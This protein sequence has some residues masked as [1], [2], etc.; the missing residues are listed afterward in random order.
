[1]SKRV[2]IE[3]AMDSLKDIKY[4]ERKKAKLENEGYTLISETASLTT[5]RLVYEMRE[6]E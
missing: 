2:I 1:M 6:G 5:G 3:Y 4:A